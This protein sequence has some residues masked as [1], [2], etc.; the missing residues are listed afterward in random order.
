MG[1]IETTLSRAYALIEDPKHHCVGGY[2]EDESG[3]SAN[4]ESDHAV[5]WCVLGAIRR[6]A[7]AYTKDEEAVNNFL[8]SVST[9]W[10]KEVAPIVNDLMGHLPTLC[11]LKTAIAEAREQGL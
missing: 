9:A 3:S 1:P 11:L 6:V 2:A 10:L 4:S 8:R 7:G 5:R